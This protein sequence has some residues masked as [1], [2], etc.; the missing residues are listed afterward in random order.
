MFVCELAFS[1]LPK[2]GKLF[3]LAVNRKRADAF[4]DQAALQPR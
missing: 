3:S 2:I 1:G 4:V